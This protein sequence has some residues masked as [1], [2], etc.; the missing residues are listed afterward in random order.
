MSD[1]FTRERFITTVGTGAIY[2]AL[3]STVACEPGERTSKVSPLHTPRD[4]LLP[5][6]SSAPPKGSAGAF[7]SRPDLSPPVIDVTARPHNQAPGYIFVAPKNGPREESPAQD[8]AMI[9]DEGGQLVWFRPLHRERRDVMNF[10]VQRYRSEP[11]LTWWEG[12]HTGYGQGEYVIADSSYREVTRVRAG[13]GYK[14]DHHEFLISHQDTALFNIFGLVLMDLSSAGGPKNAKVLDGIVQEVDIESGE[15]LFEWHSLEHVG[16]QE[17]HYQPPKNQAQ[18]PYDHVHINSIDEDHDGNLLVSARRTSTVYKIERQSG[19]IL[20]QLGGK[21]SDFEMGPG[22]RFAYQHDARRQHDGTLTIFD[23]G[24]NGATLVPRAPDRSR[25]I[26]VDLDEDEMTATLVHEYTHPDELLSLSQGNMQVLPNGNVFIGWGSQPT[27]SEFSKDGKLL[28]NARFPP[29]VES[30]RAFR[31][32]WSA[33]PRER[34]AAAAERISAGKV[35]VYASWNGATEVA[36]W[37]VL[38][39]PRLGQLHSVGSVPWD[40][41]ETAMLVR[42]AEPYLVVRAKHASGRVLGASKAVDL[43]S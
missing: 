39:G 40:G 28:F 30:Y 7:R 12:V 35:R 14:G 16:L 22:T 3:A 42:T 41:F 13:N 18:E 21:K 31:F 20:W 5:S 10:K 33:H 43:G 2:L 29:E 19:D 24:L 8:G 38:A 17:S 26:I 25:G 9:L 34:P 11:V 37:E 6:L 23:N 1:K 4:R 32:P 15:V 36:A 27:F